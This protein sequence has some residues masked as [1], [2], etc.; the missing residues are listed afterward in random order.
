MKQGVSASSW[1]RVGRTVSTKPPLP[2]CDLKVPVNY[3]AAA[4]GPIG[5][6]RDAAS[7]GNCIKGTGRRKASALSPPRPRS[8]CW[9]NGTNPTLFDGR[10]LS[11]QRPA[12]SQSV[13][14]QAMLGVVPRLHKTGPSREIFDGR[15]GMLGNRKAL[16]AK[17]VSLA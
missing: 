1:P 2:S 4:S 11:C 7:T 8:N 16:A 14:L 13:F 9:Q 10:W 12:R 5:S 6:V 3:D 15:P 17:F